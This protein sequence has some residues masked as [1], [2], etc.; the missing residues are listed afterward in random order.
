MNKYFVGLIGISFIIIIGILLI[1][2]MPLMNSMQSSKYMTAPNHTFVNVPI[3]IQVFGLENNSL[4]SIVNIQNH[5]VINFTYF[6]PHVYVFVTITNINSTI[7]LYASN[8][9]QI[10]SLI[11]VSITAQDKN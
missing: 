9:T 1:P 4:Y 5:Y 2:H 11:I 7:N 6:E 8:N 3:A 10:D